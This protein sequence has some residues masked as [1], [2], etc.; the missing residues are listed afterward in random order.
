LAKQLLAQPVSRMV[1]LPFAWPIIPSDLDLMQ[2][3]NSNLAAIGITVNVTLM[4]NASW[5]LIASATKNLSP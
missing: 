4:D 1:S 3:I 5:A 2:I